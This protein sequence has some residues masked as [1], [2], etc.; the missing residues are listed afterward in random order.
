MDGDSTTTM[1]SL[2]QY[3]IAPS[4][5]K[6]ILISEILLVLPEAI[7]SR[8]TPSHQRE[9]IST[10]LVSAFFQVAVESV[11]FSPQSTFLQT[12]QNLTHFWKD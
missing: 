9:E 6:F 2:F 3:L 5:K 7:V 8:S 1:G 4:M 10:L 11:E 12:K